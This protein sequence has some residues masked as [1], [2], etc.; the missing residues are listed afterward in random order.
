M[1]YYHSSARGLTRGAW[2][3]L[4]KLRRVRAL[5]LLARHTLPSGEASLHRF[6]D[7]Y[8]IIRKLAKM[9][10]VSGAAKTRKV[11]K[12]FAGYELAD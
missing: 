4:T 1:P 5:A 12:D 11:A 3:R 6:D 7:L 9:H 2:V 10:L 8:A